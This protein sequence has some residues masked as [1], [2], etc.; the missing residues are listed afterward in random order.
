MQSVHLKVSNS[1][2]LALLLT[3][4][5]AQ[6][7]NEL[8]QSY[9]NLSEIGQFEK[10]LHAE[11][12]PNGE[13]EIVLVDT[14]DNSNYVTFLVKKDDRFIVNQRMLLGAATSKHVLVTVNNTASQFLVLAAENRLLVIDTN[15][16]TLINSTE[17]STSPIVSLQKSPWKQSE[18]LI[19]TAS[20]I[21]AVSIDS[22]TEVRKL[23]DV[24][25]SMLAGSFTAENRKQI[26]LSTGAI[27]ELIAE[28]LTVVGN[29]NANVLS[30]KNFLKTLDEN[31]DGIHEI[32]MQNDADSQ[33]EIFDS[34]SQ[35]VEAIFGLPDEH[36][37]VH[38]INQTETDKLI[39]WS[40]STRGLERQFERYRYCVRDLKRDAPAAKCYRFDHDLRYVHRFIT[41]YGDITFD[42]KVDLIYTTE[43]NRQ[44]IIF[45]THVASQ[46][47]MLPEYDVRCM[48][49]Q[50]NMIEDVNNDQAQ[51]SCHS[52]TLFESAMSGGT[53]TKNMR[54]KISLQ[55]SDTLSR[56]TYDSEFA[57]Y[58]TSKKFEF[59]D[60]F[61]NDGK[62]D[63]LFYTYLLLD[64]YPH[65]FIVTTQEE[66]NENS[67][68]SVTLPLE[69]HVEPLKKLVYA[70]TIESHLLHGLYVQVQDST[71]YY[72]FDSEFQQI[73]DGSYVDI[74]S[75][76]YHEEIGTYALTKDGAILVINTSETP[77]PITK[78][79]E[80]DVP[81]GLHQSGPHS[82]IY[83]CSTKFGQLD[84]FSQQIDWEIN[85][86]ANNGY[87]N[88]SVVNDSKFLVTSGSAP[89]VF[90]IAKGQ[91]NQE[92]IPP[93]DYRVHISEQLSITLPEKHE[94]T[95]YAFTNFTRHG[96][97]SSIDPAPSQ[98]FLYQPQSLG[99]EY[100]EYSATQGE[101]EVAKGDVNIEVYNA[102]PQINNIEVATHW[103]KPLKITL[104]AEDD[105]ST[106][107]SYSLLNKENIEGLTWL[108]REAGILLFTPTSCCGDV[109]IQYK[110]NDG[111]VDSETG[112][113]SIKLTNSTPTAEN[114]AFD[115]VRN[116]LTTIK[117]D[118][119]DADSDLLIYTVS[120]PNKLANFILDSQTGVVKFTA[121]ESTPQSFHFEYFVSDGFA[122]SETKMVEI[123]VKNQPKTPPE[124]SSGNMHMLLLIFLLGTFVLRSPKRLLTFKKG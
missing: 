121:N 20:S 99:H 40:S 14:I 112:I 62:L 93:L 110:V 91:P 74:A 30:G 86:V 8:P 103:N 111:Y 67:L 63:K 66:A 51:L 76:A 72:Q 10:V 6:A 94:N 43:F 21:Y 119:N 24:G 61:N 83:S 68:D 115:A 28:Q 69:F 108:D 18:V 120:N 16:K 105:D 106:S 104:P 7:Q 117:L 11:K 46:Q 95:S 89:Q 118:G 13:H 79:C 27:Y 25:G 123:S 71:W 65:R 54:T 90:E 98:R 29:A 33:V 35:R 39:T 50:Q 1:F 109:H 70:R 59:Y 57:E 114:L 56:Y 97:L 100:L 92:V 55:N 34:I 113:V 52:K 45:D 122:N 2:A 47:A 80:G 22:N 124:K 88:T 42:G 101:W 17:I 84:T 75:A 96:E 81:V 85:G 26:L 53:Y 64:K 41:Y 19:T 3:A 87:V 9:F 102:Q 5:F 23:S 32:L 4:S 48:H 60:D 107:L 73:G 12:K 15:S 82:L 116:E 38:P 49:S 58:L 78:V 31:K 77:L 44:N 36:R 37:I